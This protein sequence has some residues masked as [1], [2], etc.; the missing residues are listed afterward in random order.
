MLKALHSGG[1]TGSD[2]SALFIGNKFG[3][4]TGGWMPRGFKTQDG[5]KP[6]FELLY[7]MKE[8]ESSNYVPRTHKNVEDSDGTLRIVEFFSS[9]GE[10]CT[11][12]GINKYKKPYFDIDIKNYNNKTIEEAVNWIINNKIEILNVAGNAEKTSPGIFKTSCE[13]MEKIL[14][15]LKE[16]NYI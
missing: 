8:H 6:E 5:N 3:I 2:E 7:N 11:L 15:K 13:I 16:R 1:Q 10:I 12:K 14:L 4:K 9:P